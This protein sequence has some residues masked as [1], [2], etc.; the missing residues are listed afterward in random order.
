MS[1]SECYTYV[2]ESKTPHQYRGHK[3]NPPTD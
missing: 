2:H 3:K 1:W